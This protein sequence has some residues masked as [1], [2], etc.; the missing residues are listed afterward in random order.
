MKEKE[1]IESVAQKEFKRLKNEDRQYIYDNPDDTLHFG[2]G[3]YIRNRYI[4][5]KDLHFDDQYF[6]VF[7]DDL[8]SSIIERIRE[9]VRKEMES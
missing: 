3:L 4:H 6:V 1:F 8:S 7:P 5:G 2:L 9:L